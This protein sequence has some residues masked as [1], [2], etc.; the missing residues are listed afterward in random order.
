MNYGLL[1]YCHHNN[2]LHLAWLVTWFRRIIKLKYDYWFTFCYTR[3]VCCSSIQ[4]FHW[5]ISMSKNGLADIH[6]I[7]K[8]IALIDESLKLNFMH[9]FMIFKTFIIVKCSFTI[10]A[11]IAFLFPLNIFFIESWRSIHHEWE[12]QLFQQRF[13]QIK[14]IYLSDEVCLLLKLIYICLK[15]KI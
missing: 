13:K 9:F 14:M 3:I 15:K 11:T 6:W 5:D 8:M 2:V 4:S 7:M 10:R 12:N 1:C